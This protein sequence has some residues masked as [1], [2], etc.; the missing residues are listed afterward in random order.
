[1]PVPTASNFPNSFDNDDNLFLVHDALRVRL[2][3]DYTP[4]DTSILI[5]GDQEVIDK[6]PP[7]GIITCTEQC[8]DL[9]DRAISFYYASRTDSSFDGLIVLPEFNDVAKPKGVTNVTQ[10]V[11]AR[12]HNH[13][14]DA[15]I[16]VQTF[17]GIEGQT[18]TSPLGDTLEG[19]INFLRKLILT[20]K[21]WFGMDTRVGLVP[22]CVTFTDQS[23]RLGDG[24]VIYIWDFGDQ[25]GDTISIC[26]STISGISQCHI[27]QV[28]ISTTVISAISTVPAGNN[29]VL[30]RDL[31]GGSIRKC[32]T[33]PGN[34]TVTLSVIN[35]FGIDV[36]KFDQ[37][38]N[39]RVEAPDPAVITLTPRTSQDFT[40]GEPIGGPYTTPP[41]IRSRV[42]TFID[43]E[44][45]SGENPATPGVS[46]AGEALDGTGSPIDP[47][48]EYTWN[49]GDD[50]THGDQPETRASYS[51]GGIYD[52]E[53]RVDTQYGSYRITPYEDAIDIIEAT[54]LWMF[55][56]TSQ[57]SVDG[58][59]VQA[60]EFGLNSETFKTLGNNTISINRDNSFLD[61]LSDTNTYDENAE[62]RAKNEFSRNVAFTARNPVSSGDDGECLLFWASGGADVATQT[63]QVRRYNAFSDVYSVSDPI[64]DRPWNWC[65]LASPDTT[66]FLFGTQEHT[67]PSGTNLALSERVDFDLGGLSSPAPLSL[68]TSFFGNGADELLSHPSSFDGGI[69]TNGYFATYRTAWKDSTGYILRNTAANEFFRLADFYKTEGSLADPFLSLTKLP[70][71][72]GTAKLEGQL[73]PMFNGIFFFNNSGEISAWNDLSMTW[74]VGRT[75]SATVSF[76]SLQDTN[77]SGFD[78][79][80]NTLLAVS[81]S[82]RTAYLSYDYSPNAFI[83]FNGTDQTFSSVGVRPSGRQFALGVY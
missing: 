51:I 39:A 1:M 16:A 40:P 36:V 12:H 60:W 41:K 76:R 25:S 75:S 34:Y 59:V 53:L 49:L 64:E 63:I 14:K 44:I 73:V 72:A 71:I 28:P 18:D 27:S 21:A 22:L 62:T 46:F 24:E 15:L 42:N 19:R 58:G 43:L 3:E 2:V 5:E 80:E 10:N 78:S 82:D 77:V 32:Y 69:P 81:D 20:P 29:N 52:V 30:V 83:K 11:M 37:I 38:I 67:T 79:K 9:E 23:F 31:D 54:N 45:L 66:Y 68:G 26:P 74:E 13:L 8:S 33:E 56:F 55:N 65:A 35:E 4:G 61:Y 47:V 6:F 48:I 7:T 50:L 70:D 57:T 17:V